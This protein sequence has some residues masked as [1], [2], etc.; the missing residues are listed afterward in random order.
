[1][2]ASGSPECQN[3]YSQTADCNPEPRAPVGVNAPGNANAWATTIRALNQYP[4]AI[5]SS[6]HWRKI[7]NCANSRAAVTQS[8]TSRA[9]ARVGTNAWT[10]GSLTAA[11]GH[12]TRRMTSRADRKAR[13]M[14]R[15]S[16]VGGT[17]ARTCGS[18]VNKAGASSASMLSVI[19][20]RPVADGEQLT[21]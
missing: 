12:V 14:R 9:A 4:H 20:L 21:L 8:L 17:F 11:K 7:V 15:C 2:M 18:V 6:A 3:Q 5:T 13:A 1:M 19:G 10:S 16:R